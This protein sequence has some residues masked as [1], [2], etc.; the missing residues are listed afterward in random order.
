MFVRL[1]EMEHEPQQLPHGNLKFCSAQLIA[2]LP[3]ELAGDSAA[4][5][6]GSDHRRDS[7]AVVLR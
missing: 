6:A 4:Y 3:D 5:V 7:M 2:S 1:R